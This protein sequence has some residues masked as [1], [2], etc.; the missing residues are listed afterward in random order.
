MLTKLGRQVQVVDEAVHSAGIS[1]ERL[2]L[3]NRPV[4]CNSGMLWL[5]RC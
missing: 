3:F 1:N 2:L 4:A 5:R